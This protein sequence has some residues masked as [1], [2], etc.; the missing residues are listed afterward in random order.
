VVEN[1][2]EKINESPLNWV[3]SILESAKSVSYNGLYAIQGLLKYCSVVRIFR[4]VPYLV[5]ACY[6]VFTEQ[7]STVC[8]LRWSSDKTSD[9]CFFSNENWILPGEL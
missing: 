8:R 5:D 7:G 9:P 3:N 2:A 1:L 6:W 4:T